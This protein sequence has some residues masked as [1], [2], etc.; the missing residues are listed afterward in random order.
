MKKLP[1][2]THTALMVTSCLGQVVPR[3]VLREYFSS[4]NCETEK[5]TVCDIPQDSNRGTSA[6][7]EDFFEEGCFEVDLS[8]VTSALEP[9]VNVGILRYNMLP[10]L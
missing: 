3:N 5:T 6:V 1:K 10:N 7:A 2:E 9:A 8:H 4:H